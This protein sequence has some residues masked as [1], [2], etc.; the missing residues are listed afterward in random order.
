MVGW[1]M[2]K[3]QSYIVYSPPMDGFPYLAVILAADGTAT[4]RPFN[5]AQDAAAYNRQM[6]EAGHPGKAVN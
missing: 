6:A 2:K 3:A 1:A 5:T 4:A